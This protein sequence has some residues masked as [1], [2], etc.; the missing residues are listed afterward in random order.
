MIIGKESNEKMTV[1]NRPWQKQ[2][3][4]GLFRRVHDEKT[5]IQV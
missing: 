3:F 1:A 2:V 5:N 4:S